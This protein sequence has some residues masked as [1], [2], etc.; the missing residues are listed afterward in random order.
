M[1]HCLHLGL[2]R[3]RRV[4]GGVSV[5]LAVFT[6]AEVGGTEAAVILEAVMLAMEETVET[7]ELLLGRA[8]AGVGAA[9]KARP[10]KTD[11]CRAKFKSKFKLEVSEEK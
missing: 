1:P 6:A 10:S 3:P 9:M 4:L 11:L 8:G 7:S 5:R 2:L